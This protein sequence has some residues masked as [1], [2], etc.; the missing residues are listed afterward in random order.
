MSV[1]IKEMLINVL[2]E[3][4]LKC[5]FNTYRNYISNIISDI[6]F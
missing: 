6:L 3:I 5:A 2:L 4:R 1:H